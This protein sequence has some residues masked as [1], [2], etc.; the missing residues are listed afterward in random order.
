M[1][2]AVTRLQRHRERRKAG[3]ICVSVEIDEL[4]TIAV[5]EEHRL[6]PVGGD[7]DRDDLEK[8]IQA[9]IDLAFDPNTAE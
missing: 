4:D 9:F 2:A 3:R 5:L 7:H 6:L 8:A 1:T